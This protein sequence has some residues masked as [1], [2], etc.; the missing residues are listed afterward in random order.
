MRRLESVGHFPASNGRV[1][2]ERN[3]LA[4]LLNQLMATKQ[5]KHVQKPEA[6]VGM[7]RALSGEWRRRRR[8]VQRSWRRC[9]SGAWR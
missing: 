2:G 4:A 6:C 3:E 7:R 5:I 9:S 8:R 1:G